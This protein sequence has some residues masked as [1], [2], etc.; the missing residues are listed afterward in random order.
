MKQPSEH[1]L[2]HFVISPTLADLITRILKYRSRRAGKPVTLSGYLRELILRDIRENYL[3][4]RTRNR[5]AA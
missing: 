2:L 3:K 5:S 1:I 4:T